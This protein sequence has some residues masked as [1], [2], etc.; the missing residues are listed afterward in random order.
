MLN[1]QRV[2]TI[3]VMSFNHSVAEK[4]QP[5]ARRQSEPVPPGD[6]QRL[7]RGRH[8]FQTFAGA[9][10]CSTEFICCSIFLGVHCL[11]LFFVGLVLNSIL[12][13][14]QCLVGELHYDLLKRCSAFKRTMRWNKWRSDHQRISLS[15]CGIFQRDRSGA[16][17]V[18]TK[19]LRLVVP[20][21]CDVYW[22]RFTHEN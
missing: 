7:L 14:W 9:M 17:W 4:V 19:Q 1:Y 12:L 11:V 16:K 18:A 2:Y 21:K 20:P 22:F 6:K 3:V 5:L 8:D 13:I 10:S 15:H